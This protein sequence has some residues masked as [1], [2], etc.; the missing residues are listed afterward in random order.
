MCLMM[1]CAVLFCVMLCSSS[2][3]NST[4]VGKPDVPR[5]ECEYETPLKCLRCSDRCVDQ[6]CTI[7][8]DETSHRISQ[9]LQPSDNDNDDDMDFVET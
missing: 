6:C 7:G 4:P 8:E 2:S 3:R 1:C 9:Q 5:Y